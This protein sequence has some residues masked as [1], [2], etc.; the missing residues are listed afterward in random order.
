MPINSRDKGRQTIAICG[1][2][3][4]GIS[5]GFYLSLSLPEAEILLIDKHQPVS[6]TSSQSGENFRDYWPHQSM[7]SLSQ[8]SIKLMTDLLDEFGEDTF[9]MDFSGYHFISHKTDPIFTDENSIAFQKHNRVDQDASRIHKSHPYLDS[10][11][12][13]SVFIKNAGH[14]DSITMANLMLA[15]AKKRG[16]SFMQNEIKNLSKTNVGYTVHC[17]DGSTIE[18]DQII[19]CAGPFINH[20]A[21]MLDMSFPIWNTLQRK[22]II[23]DPQHVIPRDMPFTIY[24]D[25]QTLAWSEEERELFQAN[26]EL[27][28]MT[29]PFP[30]AIHIKPESG[31]RI[32]LGWAFSSQEE[33][34]SWDFKTSDYFPQVVLKGASRFMPGLKRYTEYMPAPLIEYGGYY[35]R[36]QENWPLIGPTRLEDVYVIGALAGFGTMTACAAGELCAAYISNES[37][38]DYAAY[39]HPERYTDPQMKVVLDSLT[40]DGQL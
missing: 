15:D 3:I 2:G 29:E 22:F 34:P 4:A 6:F 39:F 30:G 14:V 17:D 13:K 25:G 9:S 40:M 33:T 26:S 8:H 21:N 23:P 27:K 12:S 31:D 32:K 36:T 18:T 24:V 5:V 1:A 37:L 28:W 16:L 7:A 38:P 10:A 35:T 11:I 20:L 19:I